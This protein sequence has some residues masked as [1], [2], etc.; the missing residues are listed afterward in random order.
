MIHIA[1]LG[2]G[3]IAGTMANTLR[4]MLEKKPGVFELYAVAARDLTRAEDFAKRYGLARAYGSYEEMVADDEVDL[5]YVATPHSHHYA[6]IKLCLE[7]GRHVLCEKAFTV[8]AQQA[9]EV[10]DLARIKGLLLAEAMWTRYMPSRWILDDLL[11]S[12]VIGTPH[13]LTANL[14]YDIAGKE[15]IQKPELAG[16]ALLDLGVYPLNFAAMVF[17][18][19]IA[20]LDSTVQMMDTGVDR[21][22]SITLTYG[23]GRMA[24]LSVTAS[25]Y[26]DRQGLIFGEKGYITVDNINNPLKIC[27]YSDPRGGGAPRV[28]D[29]PEQISGYEYQVEACLKAIQNNDVECPE[30]T[31]AD[32]VTM[33]RIADRLR[34]Q[35]NLRFPCE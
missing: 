3:N 8:N 1:I 32:T 30:M 22:E 12:G 28:I 14:A 6:H 11:D 4:R 18:Y 24:V 15:R 17:G 10:C 26:G 13:M 2:A 27:V 31:H 7:H 29:V 33:M 5:V 20:K 19:D 23:D 35:W 34:S 9:R 25:G 21:Q 16:G